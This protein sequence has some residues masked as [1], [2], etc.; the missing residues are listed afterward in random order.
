MASKR[1]QFSA[2][3][4][5]RVALAAVREV[6]TVSEL[7]S[8]HDVHPTLI[9]KWKQQLLQDG[10]QVF[11]RTNGQAPREEEGKENELYEQ[12]GRLKMELEWLK[13]KAAPFE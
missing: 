10:P 1:R 13:K 4:K 8:H 3:F 7:A 6:N 12:I 11:T 2:D 5:F 9:R